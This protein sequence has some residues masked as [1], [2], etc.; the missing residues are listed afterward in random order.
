MSY[1]RGGI[2]RLPGRAGQIRTGD[3]LL[4]KQTRYQAALQPVGD[5]CVTD[6][7]YG[8]AVEATS[9]AV[10][11]AATWPALTRWERAETGRA[12]RR[13]GWTYG[14][15]M[16]VLPVGKGTLAGWCKEIRLTS[17]QIEAIKARRP[18]GVR[19]GIP[20]DTQRKRRLEIG[21]IC[22]KARSE[23]AQ[24]LKE[25]LW[26]AGTVLYWAEGAK[27]TNDLSLVNTDPIALRLFITWVRRYLCPEAGFVLSLHL[28]EGNDEPAAFA[29]WRRAVGLEAAR[30]TKTFIKPRGTG[31][32]KNL[33][34]HGVCRVR[35]RR[36]SDHW[37]R[38]M[39]WIEAIRE[40]LRE[41][42]GT[43]PPGR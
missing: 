34:P 28:H 15:I 25:P 30:F 23:A 22:D 4:P 32:R 29:Y 2:Q 3:L 17:E 31:H 1:T 35:V 21:D 12:L 10:E 42:T 6:S 16:E 43:I 27:T 37:N 5:N 20:V 8:R 14:E 33:L 39:A 36:S 9:F 7:P 38:V 41:S 19:T 24:L 26:V 13:L 11:A 18:P 40:P